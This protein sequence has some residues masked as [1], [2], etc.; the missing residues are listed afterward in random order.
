MNLNHLASKAKLRLLSAILSL[1]IL[2]ISI[3]SCQKESIAPAGPASQT[4]PTGTAAATNTFSFANNLSGT[5]YRSSAPIS[6]TGKN[7][8]TIS[9]LTI[10]AGSVPAISLKNCINVHITK[11][12]FVNG[13]AVAAVGIWLYNCT[14][15]TIDSCYFSNVSGGIFASNSTQIYVAR[16]QML[17]MNGPQPRGQFVQFSACY[18]SGNKIMGNRFENIMGESNPEDAI[19]I[20]MSHGVSG[21]PIT[22]SGNWI[23]GGGPSSTGGGINLGDGGGSYQ[24]ASNNILVNPGQYGVAVSAGN[25]MQILSN[26]I[27]AAKNTFT[28]VG[29][30]AWNQYSSTTGCS[31]VAISGNHVNWTASGGYQNPS[32][33]GGNC[34][35]IVGWANNAFGDPNITASILPATIIT[36]K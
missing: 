16:N 5:T 25:N 24:T 31:I 15:V 10:T 13:T 18:G 30:F 9:G 1:G 14:N 33:D 28:N 22:V 3:S 6:Y 35:T 11:S 26:K 20:Y 12:R 17:N 4:T 8:I 34:G 21:S 29:T 23:R 32:W 36:M 27:Y 19:N 7:N 2:T